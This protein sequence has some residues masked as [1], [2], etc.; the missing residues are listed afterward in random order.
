M[1]AT[2]EVETTR[3]AAQEGLERLEDR[4]IQIEQMLDSVARERD[5][6]RE[7]YNSLLL[8]H[9]TEPQR[10]EECEVGE[11]K[12]NNN[13]SESE[14]S[15]VSLPEKGRLLEAVM[16]AGPLLQTLMLAG[17]LPRWRVPPPPLQSFEIPPVNIKGNGNGND[18]CK[19]C[20]SL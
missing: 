3:I 6:A 10:V 14:E 15:V 17:P 16:N 8:H 2:L 1:Y 19:R 12:N 20:P 18:C 11:C 9:L 13:H 5:E 4:A 7:T